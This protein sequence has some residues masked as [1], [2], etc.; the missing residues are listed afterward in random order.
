[1]QDRALDHA[2][3]PG[4]GGGVA[5]VLGFERLVFLIELLA[6]C[7]AQIAQVNTA[8]LHDLRCIGIVDKR[9]KQVLQRGIFVAAFRRM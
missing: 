9:Q 7:V 4:G 8:G 6:Y 3:K 1:M 5:L 2:L